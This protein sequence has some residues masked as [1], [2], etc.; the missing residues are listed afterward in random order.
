MSGTL[1]WEI[2]GADW[3]NR[4]ASRFVDAAGLRWHVQVAGSGPVVLLAHGT[5][6]S[7]HSWR[8]ML[9]KLAAKFTVVAPDLPGHGFTSAPPDDRLTLP[10]MAAAVSDLVKVL[11]IEPKLAVGHSAGAAILIRA[12]LDGGFKPAALISFN[13]ALLPFGGL[14][15]Q[16]FSPLAK[17]LFVNPYVPGFFAWRAED[18]AAVERL[19]KGTGSTIDETGID[20]YARLFRSSAHVAATLGM[21]ANWDLEPLR[22]DMPNLAVPLF[23]VAAANDRSIAPEA[24]F[25]VRDL[26]PGATVEYL[27]DVGHLG[28]EERPDLFLAVIEKAAAQYGVITRL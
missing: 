14:A 13:G 17:F 24:A 2:D 15:G 7:T 5:G 28:H 21:M 6:A 10:G 19:L 11:G 4:G 9:P 26:V 20:L 22:R 25:T 16:I 1:L 18:R 23:L 3:P 8:D 27:R 12:V